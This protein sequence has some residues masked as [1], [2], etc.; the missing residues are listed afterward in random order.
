MRGEFGGADAADGDLGLGETL[1]AVG[2]E[3]PDREAGFGGVELDIRNVA[4]FRLDR[5]L[6][7]KGDGETFG[8]MPGE[9]PAQC[10]TGLST[11]RSYQPAGSEVGEEVDADVVAVAPVRRDLQDCGAAEAAVGE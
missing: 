3:H 4:E 9:Q 6:G 7:G 2:G 10:H 1:A 11:L 8:Q 5:E